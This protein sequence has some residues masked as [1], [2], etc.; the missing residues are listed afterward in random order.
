MWKHCCIDLVIDVAVVDRVNVESSVKRNTNIVK[1][2]G[3]NDNAP[4]IKNIVAYV[5]HT[6]NEW[7]EVIQVECHKE[8]A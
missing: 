2:V 6:P 7:L 8:K 1:A 5:I 4:I 3:G